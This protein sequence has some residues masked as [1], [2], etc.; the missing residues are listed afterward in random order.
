M[1]RVSASLAFLLVAQA[2]ACSNSS[3]E[4]LTS[5]AVTLVAVDSRDFPDS[6]ACTVDADGNLSGGTFVAEL[7]DVSGI[8]STTDDSPVSGTKSLSAEDNEFMVQSSEA[9]PCGKSVAFADA[10]ALR[11]Y[12]VR[13]NVYA[14]LDGDPTT[15][16]VCTVEGT[17]VAVQKSNGKCPALS[18]AGTT[19]A[20]PALSLRCFGWQAP[21]VNGTAGA[22]EPVLAINQHTVVAHYC[23]EATD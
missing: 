21:S 20:T 15:S 8:I 14:D 9:M 7:I 4:T 17:R 16:D 2:T 11:R 22:G 10:V 1:S 5:D 3:T 18:D 13:V 23:V 19:I 12:E 6:A